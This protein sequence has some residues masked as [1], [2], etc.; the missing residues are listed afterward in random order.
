MRIQDFALPN[1]PGALLRGAAWPARAAWARSQSDHSNPVNPRP[2]MRNTSRRL[3]PSHKR[4]LRPRTD[5][6]AG[7]PRH[8]RRA[9]RRPQA[10]HTA[11]P[12]KRIARLA[13]S[14]RLIAVGTR[15]EEV[16]TIHC[17]LP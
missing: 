2:P 4:T 10:Y 15:L 11:M 7:D 12:E 13:G 9:A 1:A 8:F 14:Q 6:M 17:V 16:G 5:S 3:R